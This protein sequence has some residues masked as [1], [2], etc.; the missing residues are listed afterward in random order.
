MVRRGA[1]VIE[2]PHGTAGTAAADGR[3]WWDSADGGE[4]TENWS[5][6]QADRADRGADELGEVV[7]VWIGPPSGRPS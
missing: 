2:E 1:L 5:A 3:V 4:P 6:G 7:A